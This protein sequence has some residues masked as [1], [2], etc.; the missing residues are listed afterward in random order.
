MFIMLIFL[1]RLASK[2]IICQIIN[3][4]FYHNTYPS[5]IVFFHL[6]AKQYIILIFKQMFRCANAKIV[7]IVLFPQFFIDKSFYSSNT[8]F[9]ASL[10]DETPINFIL[11]EHFHPLR[12]LAGRITLSNPS[13]AASCTRCS[14]LETLLTSPVKPTSPMM[15]SVGLVGLSR[16]LEAILTAIARS[17]AGSSNFT[18]PATLI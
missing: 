10:T 5:S 6:I 15:Q 7:L 17:I 2:D 16:K 14:I 3:Q 12:L 8:T 18:P 1:L 11:S 4:S 13:F 9:K